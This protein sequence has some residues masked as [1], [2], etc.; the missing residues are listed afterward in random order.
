MSKTNY[1]E[2][3]E[4]CAYDAMHPVV[5]QAGENYKFFK[6]RSYWDRDAK[7][8]CVYI[9]CSCNTCRERHNGACGEFYPECDMSS[10]SIMGHLYDIGIIVKCE[11]D[12]KLVLSKNL[13]SYVKTL[14]KRIPKK[15]RNVYWCAELKKY[16]TKPYSK[17]KTSIKKVAKLRDE[18]FPPLVKAEV[19][20]HDILRIVRSDGENEMCDCGNCKTVSIGVYEKMVSDPKLVQT[21]SETGIATGVEGQYAVCW[22]CH[23]SEKEQ[24]PAAPTGYYWVIATVPVQMLTPMGPQIFLQQRYVL[25]QMT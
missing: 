12:D 18:D 3:A 16:R 8:A 21:A 5:Q 19:E 1:R 25:V 22:E 4:S 11:I 7:K 2:R 23:N 20:T 14:D 6:L 24:Q 13:A 17:S 9:S 10:N 15:A